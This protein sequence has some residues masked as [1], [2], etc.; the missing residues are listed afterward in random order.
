MLAGD[1]AALRLALVNDPELVN[2]PWK[3]N[4]LIEWATQP[5]HDVAPEII[6]EIGRAHV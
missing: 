2:V 5:P 1:E 4:T 6:H 3:G